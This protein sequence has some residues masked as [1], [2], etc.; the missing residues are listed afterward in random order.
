ME[1]LLLG[2]GFDAL[3]LTVWLVLMAALFVPLERL[4]GAARQ[5]VWRAQMVPDLAYYFLNGL[6]LSLLLAVPSAILGAV[7]HALVPEPVLAFTAGLPLWVRVLAGLALGDLGAYW[8]HRWSHEI[9]LLWRFHAIHHSAT[10]VDWLTNTRAHPVDLLI[11]RFC[12]LVPL[13]ALGLAQSSRAGDPLPE[14]VTIVGTVWS[15][16]VHANLTWRFGF[17]ER[18]VA[19]PAF[20]RWHHTNDAMRDRNYAA[21]LP[22][23]DALFGTL[24]L[25]KSLPTE[26]GIDGQ[27]PASVGAQLAR[28]FEGPV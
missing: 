14:I 23:I 25:P 5:R 1:R 7:A 9:P 15:F 18:L 27:M 19:T 8:G 13:F 21:I 11:T 6:T 26:Y 4:F 28:P 16:F 17:L 2:I 12:G 10:G 24:H 20:H 22:G 3:R